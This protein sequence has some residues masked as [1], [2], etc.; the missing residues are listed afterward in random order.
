MSRLS[1]SLPLALFC[2][3]IG[4]SL[5][6]LPRPRPV[7]LPPPSS[8]NPIVVGQ[9]AVRGGPPLRI[10]SARGLLPLPT[11][12]LARFPPPPP[13]A[14]ALRL[15]SDN[16]C[17]V[18][19]PNGNPAPGCATEHELS[20]RSSRQPRETL[21]HRSLGPAARVAPRTG[22][23]AGRRQTAHPGLAAARVVPQGGSGG[24]SSAS[25]PLRPHVT[26]HRLLRRYL[27]AAPPPQARHVLASRPPL[28]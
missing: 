15:R 13:V 7:P 6:Y 9:A 16:G 1:G 17:S 21:R 8:P 11:R 20:D 10:R 23:F 2:W 19:Q 5:C 28:S 14:H 4:C 18:A 25:S 26:C 22:P 12:T 27:R 3:G 24:T